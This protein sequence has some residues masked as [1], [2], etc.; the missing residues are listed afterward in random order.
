MSPRLHPALDRGKESTTRRHSASRTTKD[1]R[2]WTLL[3]L[4]P[5]SGLG[6]GIEAYIGAILDQAEQRGAA[7]DRCILVDRQSPRLSLLRKVAFVVRASRSARRL[8]R[9]ARPQVLVFLPSF[10]VL[11]LLLRRIVG[12]QRVEVTVFFYGREIWSAGALTRWVWRRAGLKRIAISSFGAGALARVGAAQ[13][14]QPG[15]R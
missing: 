13:F 10:A 14:L 1:D 6:G 15:I 4:I 9:S 8:R 7:I 12:S 2:T 3:A 11:G 5:S